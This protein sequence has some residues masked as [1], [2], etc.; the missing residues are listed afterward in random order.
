MNFQ[1][2]RFWTI[3]YAI[4]TAF[5]FLPLFWSFRY[6]R[7]LYPFAAWNVMMAGGDLERGRTYYVLRGETL[8]GETIDITPI[9]LTNGLTGRTWTM[10]NAVVDNRSFKLDSIHPQNTGLINSLGGVQNLPVGARLP[11]LLQAWGELY[12]ERQSPTSTHRLRAVR[13]DTYRWDSRSY[14]GYG[15]FVESWRK[16]L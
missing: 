10:V 14:S 2:A 1:S 11:D 5:I 7:N 12:N 8:S 6:I 16:E 9:Q 15:T 4:L 3:K 13:L